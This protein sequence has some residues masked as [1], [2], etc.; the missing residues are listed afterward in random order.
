MTGLFLMVSVGLPCVFPR[1][2]FVI[3]GMRFCYRPHTLRDTQPSVFKHPRHWKST[4][5]I[6]KK[7]LCLSHSVHLK[8]GFKNICAIC[9]RLCNVVCVVVCVCGMSAK[10]SSLLHQSQP[11]HSWTFSH[12]PAE[13]ECT[14]GHH[15][16]AEN[17]Q[18][19]DVIDGFVCECK[20]GYTRA[21]RSVTESTFSVLCSSRIMLLCP[22]CGHLLL[23]WFADIEYMSGWA[24]LS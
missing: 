10:L 2:T 1:K 23:N 14:N 15:N 8:F 21:D 19:S 18:C 4:F 7:V 9:G 12:C 24:S 6:H 13:N 17:E 20:T 5:G 3:A 22:I 11:P 16:C